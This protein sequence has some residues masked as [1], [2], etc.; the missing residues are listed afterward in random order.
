VWDVVVQFDRMRAALLL[1]GLRSREPDGSAGHAI[2]LYRLSAATL[3]ALLAGDD[4]PA[5]T[6]ESGRWN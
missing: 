2:L 6:A 3:A 5:A 1:Q 4:L